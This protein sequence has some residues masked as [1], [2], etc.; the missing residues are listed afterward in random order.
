MSDQKWPRTLPPPLDHTVLC[1]PQYDNLQEN[2]AYCRY[3]H[4]HLS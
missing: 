1:V 2:N 3:E 4:S